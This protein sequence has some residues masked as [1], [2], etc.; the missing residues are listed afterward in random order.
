MKNSEAFIFKFELNNY[1]SIPIFLPLWC[2]DI[3][4]P[5]QSKNNYAN[6][7]STKYSSNLDRKDLDEDHYGLDKVKKRIIEYLA[8]R[9]IK[10]SLKGPILC[11][12]GP[13]GVG[14]TSIGKSVAYTLGREFHR[15]DI[16]FM[17]QFS[18]IYNFA[19]LIQFDSKASTI[20]RIK[21]LTC[22]LSSLKD[23]PWWC[24]RPI[25][26]SRS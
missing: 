10:N 4:F 9:Q 7:I 13:P 24:M 22:T 15:Y 3:Y 17:D 2:S 26:H 8:V 23:S 25:R 18:N 21:Y 16:S 14:K 20:R 5:E 6:F 11:F 1:E 19:F 12:V